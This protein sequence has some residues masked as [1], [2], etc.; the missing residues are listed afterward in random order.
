[1]SNLVIRSDLADRIRQI[2]RQ[3]DQ[4]VEDFLESLL[5]GVGASA[6]A[7]SL[8]ALAEAAEAADIRLG[9]ADVAERSREILAEEYEKRAARRMDEE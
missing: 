4:P 6:P 3:H 2:A 8:A 7:G 5:D 1:M 9:V